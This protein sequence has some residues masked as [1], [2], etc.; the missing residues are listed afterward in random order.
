MTLTERSGKLNERCEFVGRL[1]GQNVL[2]ILHL[3]EDIR[4]FN[5]SWK[6]LIKFNFYQWV[7]AGI[8]GEA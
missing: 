6:G 4:A 8:S 5:R 2:L 3:L 1:R 7:R